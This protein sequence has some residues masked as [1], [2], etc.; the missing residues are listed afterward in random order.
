MNSF[1]RTSTG[2]SL[3]IGNKPYTIDEHHQNYE[4]VKA[5]LREKRWNDIPDL[6][7][8]AK[9]VK[10]YVEATLQGTSDL[11]V[12]LD[13]SM[14]TFRGE[15]VHGVLVSRILDM[16]ADQFDVT[17]MALFLANL[18]DNPSNKAVEQL[19]GWMEANGITI[20]EDGYLLAFKRVQDDFTSFY[21]S[22]TDN[23]IGT[24]PSLPR[25]KVDDR[26]D[27]TCS[28]GLHFCSQAYLPSYHG[29]RGK[30]LLLKINPR[31]V[32]SIPTDYGNAKGRACAYLVLD[33][34][35]GDARTGI[36]EHNVIPQAVVISTDDVNRSNA[37]KLGYAA[38]YK[39]GRGK[40]ARGTSINYAQFD[41]LS[42]SAVAL[43]DAYNEYDAGYEVGRKDGRCQQPNLFGTGVTV[44][45]IVPSAF[46]PLGDRVINVL[47]DQIGWGDG[48]DITLD[49]NKDDLNI[50]SMD[51]V[52]IV[53]ALED[54]FD[55][56]LPDDAVEK[57]VNVADLINVVRDAVNAP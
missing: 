22:K 13:S 50:D 44:V 24:T 37:F 20:T 2:M 23:S 34:L 47:R 39:D 41:D 35:K 25:N 19:Y 48:S 10:A 27:V 38:G 29:G 21:D 40:K 46:D 11:K 8:V 12:D 56:E 43:R 31:D 55:I 57:V 54:E 36:E 52:E 7:N 17:P 9:A 32:V 6:I 30:V 26:S 49:M 28:H 5:A 4:L 51:E 16:A 14:V 15:E 53:M 18:Y 45:A 3:F 1:L 42:A 33:E